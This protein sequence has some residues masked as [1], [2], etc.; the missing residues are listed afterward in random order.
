ME[1]KKLI[2]RFA[3]PAYI[4][5][6]VLLALG[7][8]LMAHADFGVSV[9][10]APAYIISLKVDVFTFGMSEYILQAVLLIVMC[11]IIR[12]FRTAYIFS[13]V[14]AFIYGCVL[15]L[16]MLVVANIPIEVMAFRVFIY[17]V[18]FIV[19]GSGVALLIHT[20]LA[21]E[22]YEL[23]V[24]E[25]SNHFSFKFTKLKICYDCASCIVSFGM[26]FALFGEIRGIGVG[27]VICAVF[28]GIL[29]GFIG[30]RMDKYIDF[31][32]MLSGKIIDMLKVSEMK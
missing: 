4:I 10:V 25:L 20:Y 17:I 32:P 7:T 11:L 22:V 12:K 18:G 19:S 30:K 26:S 1:N 27:S 31:S 15:D 13:F 8:A 29:I 2:K 24:K 3:E 14:T 21:P 9:I 23:F 5:G 6:I 28:N 16:W